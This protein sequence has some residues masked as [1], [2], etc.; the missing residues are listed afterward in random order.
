MANSEKT[1]RKKRAMSPKSLANLKPFKKGVSGNPSGPA[2]GYKHRATTLVPIR[3]MIAEFKNP[4]TKETETMSVET[5]MEYAIVG[6]AMKGNVR[7]YETV[8]DSVYGKLVDKSETEHKGEIG[9][10]VIEPG[11]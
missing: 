3:E 8:K 4:V 5:R 11:E 9:V 6:E 10:R 7:A 1:Q 2:P